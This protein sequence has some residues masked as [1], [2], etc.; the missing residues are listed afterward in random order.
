MSFYVR[1]KKERRCA[2]FSHGQ[3]SRAK[4]DY[5]NVVL[6]AHTWRP[7]KACADSAEPAPVSRACF[8]CEAEEGED[9]DGEERGG[10]IRKVDVKDGP[11]ALVYNRGV[12]VAERVPVRVHKA[13]SVVKLEP[14][15]WG[16]VVDHAD[17]FDGR[18]EYAQGKSEEDVDTSQGED[19]KIV[20]SAYGPVAL[21]ELISLPAVPVEN[22]DDFGL[23]TVSAIGFLI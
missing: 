11:E 16:R 9:A 19:A 14:E 22:I 7:A 3:P 2:L 23:D 4:L 13:P 5:A 18:T 1:C 20:A 10:P 15:P 6:F 17:D 21:Q 8:R 12:R